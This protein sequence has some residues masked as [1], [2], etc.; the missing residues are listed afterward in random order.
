[1]KQYLK[2]AVQA[3]LTL[4]MLLGLAGA[5]TAPVF[6]AS[7][8][9]ANPTDPN[10][11]KVCNAAAA[12]ASKSAACEGIAAAGGSCGT[13]DSANDKF[14]SIIT[15]IINVLTV[16]V[17]AICVVMIIIGGFRYVVSGG[18]SNGIQGAKNTI[19]YALV[20]LVVVVFSRTIVVFVLSKV[21]G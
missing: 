19:I 14:K 15:S 1:M 17:G 4:A 5:F 8:P 12:N 3:V 7:D 10:V 2:K 11:I 13:P 21:N 16:V 18:D 9:C 6:A 20:G